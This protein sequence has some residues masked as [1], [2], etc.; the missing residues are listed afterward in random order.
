MSI[1]ELQIMRTD[2]GQMEIE[3]EMYQVSEKLLC[4]VISSKL[5]NLPEPQFTYMP[6]GR[7]L[8]TPVVDGAS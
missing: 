3:W 4:A 2:I 8:G 7:N 5:L 1:Y 6:D